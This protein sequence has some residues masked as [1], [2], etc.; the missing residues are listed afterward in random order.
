MTKADLLADPNSCLNKA[1][2]D[3]PL[4]VLRAQD[5]IAPA[6]V[7]YWADLLQGLG[8]N[9]IKAGAARAL[10]SEMTGWPYRKLPD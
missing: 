6:V 2:A 9:P 1:A 3:E 5:L 4:F 7:R 10:A 8:G